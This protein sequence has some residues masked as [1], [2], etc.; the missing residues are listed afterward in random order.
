[1]AVPVT[2]RY[3]LFPPLRRGYLLRKASVMTLPIR[4]LSSPYPAALA[5]CLLGLAA[6]LPLAIV[7]SALAQD[8]AA[9][10][11]LA[12]DS[13]DIVIYGGTSAGV[14]AAV[15]AKRMGKSVLLIEPTDR[16]GGLTT[17]GLGQTDIGNKAAVG[18][19]AREFYQAIKKHYSTPEAWVWQKQD[20]YQS[21]GQSRS[22]ADEDAMWTFEPHVA[23]KI[24][25]Q[26]IDE[27]QIPVVYSQRLDRSGG[28]ISTRSL[29]PRII[30]IRMESGETFRGRTFI[31]ATYEGDLMAAANVPYTVGREANEK[32][33][34]TLSGVQTARA[35][36]HQFVAGVDP[37]VTPGDLASGLLPFI[38]PDAPLP[39]GSGDHRVQAYCFRMCM[40][41]H[42][43]NRIAFHKPEGYEPQWYELLLR[44]FEAGERR[45]PLSIG[46]MPNRKT[47]TNNNFGFST[48]FIG[49][50]YDYPEASYEQREAIVKRH[51][52]YQQGLMW[53]LANHPRVPEPIR[54]AVSR[55]GMCRD[56]F[57]PGGG[58]QE[59]LYIREARRMVSDYVMTQHHCQGRVEAEIPVGMAAYTMDSHHVQRHVDPNGH[60]RNEGDVQVGGFSP[61]PIDYRSIVPGA[62]DCSN[63]LVP[64]CLSASHMA[65]GSIRMEPVFMVLGQSAAT[66]AAHAIDEQL[67]VQKIDADKLTKRL[68]ADK[69]VL[70][71]TG[72]KRSGPPEGIN[73]KTLPGLVIDD[74]QAELRGFHSSGTTVGPF[75]GPHYRHDSDAEK[76]HQ[77]IR[78]AFQVEKGG[79]YEVRVSYTAFGNRAT[80][81]PVT[82]AHADG[83]TEVRINQRKPAAI[84]R[85]FEPVGR[86]AFAADTK[87]WVEISNAGTDG[88]VIADAVQLVP[89]D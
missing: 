58:W 12:D 71:W 28:V 72:P 64:V 63:L 85:L 46:L 34:E 8:A 89:V 16:L 50:N 81:V 3:R 49:Q 82:I 37:Y 36:H 67:P 39:D 54:E 56:E 18:G 53:T 75:V 11:T 9:A 13:Y 66:A 48:D 76:G 42:P 65:F 79:D 32:H 73:P 80:N 20:E 5:A 70:E 61:F 40:T 44:N 19:I 43:D 87:Y 68:L 25:Q 7:R 4:H 22:G 38:E 86:Y 29:P 74:Q 88:H 33:G 30:G 24:Y 78:F 23:L 35:V 6:L 26:W 41:D 2:P 52:L 31:D 1:M 62:K 55:W 15:Q 84:D 17:G 27:Y 51:R 57:Q 83:Q 77:T 69:Q 47:D 45:V 21:Q 59:Q 10:T 14:A 60:A